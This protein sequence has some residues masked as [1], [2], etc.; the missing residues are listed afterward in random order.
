MPLGPLVAKNLVIYVPLGCLAARNLVFHVGQGQPGTARERPDFEISR[1]SRPPVGLAKTLRNQVVRSLSGAPVGG[2]AF[3]RPW[4]CFGAP[5]GA[6]VE[7]GGFLFF[8]NE[9]GPLTQILGLL[10]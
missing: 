1:K 4:G 6:A 10:Y 2:G 3:G 9:I 8:S 5:W 7:G